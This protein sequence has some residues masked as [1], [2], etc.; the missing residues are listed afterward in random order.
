MVF[1]NG[2][3]AIKPPSRLGY[4]VIKAMIE[5]PEPFAAQSTWDEQTDRYRG[6]VCPKF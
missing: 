1:K 6:T 5:H 4:D 3:R 2:R